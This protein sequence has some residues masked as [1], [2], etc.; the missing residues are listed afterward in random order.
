ML[1]IVISD[2]GPFAGDDDHV[3]PPNRVHDVWLVKNGEPI[4]TYYM[5]ASKI[6]SKVLVI[7]QALHALGFE[8]SIEDDRPRHLLST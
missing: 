2:C 4:T 5:T 1:C 8:V 7:R 6:K 3:R